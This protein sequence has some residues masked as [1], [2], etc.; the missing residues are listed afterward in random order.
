MFDE[1]NE[2]DTSYDLRFRNPSSFLLAGATNAGK[3]TFT[4]NLLRNIDY[5]FEN[6]ECKKNVIY[7]YREYQPN[8]KL[9]KRE[10][11]VHEWVNRLP[12]TQDIDNFTS[13][14][15]DTGSIFVIDDFQEE[16]TKDTVKIFTTKSHHRNCVLI[17]LAQN[18]FCKNPVFREIS[19]NST[20]ILLF[21]NPRDASQINCFAK[22]FSP[23]NTAWVVKA[24]QEATRYPHSYLLFDTHQ[25]TPERL[26]VRSHVLPNEL[27]MRVYIPQR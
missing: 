18:I 2:D 21:K 10:N 13:E 7:F 6:P 20:Y 5:M 16:L 26:R 4:L 11:I 25:N 23:G 3:T 22:Q 1:E 27:P 24:Y 19:L 14:H 17:I 12:T 8:F 9:F 15:L